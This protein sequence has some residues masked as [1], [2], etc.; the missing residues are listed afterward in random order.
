[1]E[2]VREY[3][4]LTEKRKS[5]SNKRKRLE[6]ELD[7]LKISRQRGNKRTKQASIKNQ[8]NDLLVADQEAYLALARLKMKETLRLT[9]KNGPITSSEASRSRLISRIEWQQYCI[10]LLQE[11]ME[12]FIER[13]GNEDVFHCVSLRIGEKIACLVTLFD[14]EY[15]M[16]HAR[17][18]FAVPPITLPFTLQPNPEQLSLT[19]G[20]IHADIWQYLL[21]SYK[22]EDRATLNVLRLCCVSLAIIVHSLSPNLIGYFFC[23]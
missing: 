23:V 19:T 21:S 3:R 12:H 15:Q 20:S 13:G 5:I 14:E 7:E 2:T 17:P 1:M 10:T 6:S 16:P 11:A 22:I 9:D 8:L 4:D 18:F